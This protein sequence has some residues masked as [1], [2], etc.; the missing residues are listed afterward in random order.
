M[1]VLRPRPG[2]FSGLALAALLGGMAPAHAGVDTQTVPQAIP[3]AAGD[4]LTWRG[5][6][7]FGTVDAGILN[8][9]RG[10]PIN[11]DS[12]QGF[13][14]TIGKASRQPVTA[15]APNGLTP[16]TM[17]L[18]GDFKLSD[19]VSA[20]FR[21]EAGFDPLTLRLADGPKSLV[22]NNDRSVATQS[23]SSDSNQAGQVLNTAGFV[24]LNSKTYGALTFGRQSGLLADKIIEYDPNGASY[25]FSVAGGASAVR[26]IGVAQ[27]ARLNSSLKYAAQIGALRFGA[28]YQFPGTQYALFTADGVSGRATE[29]GLGGD[30][31]NFSADFLYSQDRK[32]VV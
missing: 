23:A 21:L 28:Q 4:G 17:G 20:I 27:G 12:A 1:N 25:A 9:T 30:Y 13:N 5:I 18:K 19:D 14:Y 2:G 8:Q 15:L 32:S 26:G 22:D 10:A 24:G 29:I 16:S 6:T 7:L 31:G 3:A 11:L